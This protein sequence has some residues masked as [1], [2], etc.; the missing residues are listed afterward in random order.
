MM[1]MMICSN[2]LFW[3]TDMFIMFQRLRGEEERGGEERR[4]GAGDQSVSMRPFNH[5]EG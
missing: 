1:M 4:G 2:P 3:R 5:L